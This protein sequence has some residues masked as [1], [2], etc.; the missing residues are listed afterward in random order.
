MTAGLEATSTARGLD[1]DQVAV[2]TIRFLA[3]DMVEAANSGHPGMP[4]GAAP[5]AWALFSRHLRFDPGAPDWPDRDRFV[6][7]A[8]HGS[9]L[10]YALLHMFGYD[11]PVEELRR[12][13]QLGSKTP[14]HP[15]FGHTPGVEATTGPLGQGLASAVGLALG[16]RMLAARFPEL[17]DHFTYVIA[18][19]GCLMEGVSHEAG[20]LAGHLRL[21]RLIVLFDDN[22]ITIDGSTAQSCGDDQL[23]RFSAYGWHVLRVEDGTDVGA[24]DDAILRARED[25]RPSLIAVRTVIG[26]GAPGVQGTPKAHGSP[27]GSTVLQA[28]KTAAGWDAPGFTVPE[29]VSAHCAEVAERGR[30][31]HTQWEHRRH[32]LHLTDLPRAEEWGRRMTRALPDLDQVLDG[33]PVGTARATRQS[34][35]AALTALAGALPEL[36]GGSADLAG[37]TG[38]ST[39]QPAVSATDYSGAKINFGIREFAMAA[40]LNGLSL[41]GG[42]RPYGSTF[43]VFGDYLRPALRLSALMGQ[44]VIY[45]LTHDSVAVGEDGPTHQPIEH[46][47]SLRLIPGVRVLRPADDAETLVAWKLAL[48]R[49]DGPTVLVLSRQSLPSMSDADSDALAELGARVVHD[50]EDPQVDL[51]ASG[52]EVDLARRAARLLEDQG[53]RSRVI[54]VMWRERFVEVRAELPPAPVCVAV[55]AGVTN[56]WRGLA[57]AVVG[58]DAFGFSGPGDQVLAHVGMTPQAV[59]DAARTAL[60]RGRGEI[61]IKHVR[62]A[63]GAV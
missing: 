14:G 38:T 39:G 15:E 21:G 59:A 57:D 27:L 58:I 63:G 20:S 10:Q 34:S 56:G 41:H 29:A 16:E 13:R 45:V 62:P 60:D 40:V 26:H 37:S 5:M 46:V 19:D 25:Q 30:T 51:L 53:I 54:S 7:S 9:A 4:M 17:V 44:P 18:G 28:A 42:F 8:G 61:P 6:L 24:I 33:I 55:E 31:A 3:A 22:G 49:L 36:V 2:D 12:F 43:L 32:E 11:L 50:V 35:Q 47:E 23:A 52:S 48:E 1:L